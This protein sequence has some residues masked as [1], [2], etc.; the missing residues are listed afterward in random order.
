[1]VGWNRTAILMFGVLS[2]GGL[3]GCGGGAPELELPE[4]AATPTE[5]VETFLNAARDA[6]QAR[7]T[8]EVE[9]AEQALLRM[10]AVFGTENGTIQRSYSQEEVRNR[11]IVLSAC[12]R[13]SEFRLISR[14]EPDSSRRRADI[15]VELT[16]GQNT[17][18]L[19]FHLVRGR[20]DRWFIERVDLST[21]SC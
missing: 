10:A 18:T 4:G 21:F 3:G 1:M 5:A 17:S 16:R 9:Q 11:M 20:G 19:P 12:L 15:S 6:V 7:Q 14:Y 8:G 2:L 13:P